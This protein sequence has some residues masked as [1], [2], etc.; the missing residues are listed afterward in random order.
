MQIGRISFNN[1]AYLVED[2]MKMCGEN[3][4]GHRWHSKG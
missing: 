2:Y 4:L 3:A 1:V